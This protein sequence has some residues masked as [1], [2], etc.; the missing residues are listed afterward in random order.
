MLNNSEVYQ[1]YETENKKEKFSFQKMM[2][3]E[4]AEINLERKVEEVSIDKVEKQAKRVRDLGKLLN[5]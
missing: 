3:V 1:E 5:L 2:H 4:K